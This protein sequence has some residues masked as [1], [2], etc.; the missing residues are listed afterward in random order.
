[1]VNFYKIITFFGISNLRLSTAF[2][3]A[4]QQKEESSPIKDLLG[5]TSD[6]S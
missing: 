5:E 2:T 1:L 4:M 6:E 3:L